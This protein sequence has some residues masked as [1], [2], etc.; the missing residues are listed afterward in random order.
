MNKVEDDGFMNPDRVSTLIDG[1]F[2]IAMTLLIL[3]LEVPHI[4]GQLSDALILSYLYNIVSPFTSFV[5]SFILLAM[6]WTINH[7]QMHYIKRVDKTY[8]WISIIL[9]LF[10]V[11]VPFSTE[12]SGMYGSYTIPQLIFNLN[13]L[14]VAILL[15]LSIY[16]SDKKMLIEDM[17]EDKKK[18]IKRSSAFFIIVALVAVVLSFIAPSWSTIVYMAIIL[19]KLL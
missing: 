8:L 10:I 9:L 15:Y 18:T 12:I 11:I 3:S 6:F 14:G 4:S 16:Y 19:E 1:I 2:A 7:S 17:N 13:L 5:L